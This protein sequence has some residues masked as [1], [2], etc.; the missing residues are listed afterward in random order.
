MQVGWT[1]Y[2]KE[3]GPVLVDYPEEDAFVFDIET[4]VPNGHLPVMA[5]AVSPKAW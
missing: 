5:C 4:C 3:K 2:D 1:K